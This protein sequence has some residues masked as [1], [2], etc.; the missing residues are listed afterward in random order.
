MTG[1]GVS[2]GQ[3]YSV[4][5]PSLTDNTA[6]SQSRSAGPVLCLTVLG[7]LGVTELP[8]RP[9]LGHVEGPELRE[10]RPLADVG[11]QDLARDGATRVLEVDDG[12][13]GSD[14]GK[15]LDHVT[16][17]FDQHHDK[18]VDLSRRL[19]QL[20]ILRTLEAKLPVLVR[21]R[22]SDLGLTS[23]KDLTI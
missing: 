3:R 10:A 1:A 12:D 22:Y 4:D 16:V 9:V 23:G 8:R 19:T 5:P 6:S 2:A 17:A 7:A 13:E 20:E 18:R 11:G 21:I 14:L 15:V